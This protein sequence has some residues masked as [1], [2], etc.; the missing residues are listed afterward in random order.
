MAHHVLQEAGAMDAKLPAT[1]GVGGEEGV[2]QEVLGI[3]LSEIALKDFAHS[4]VGDAADGP[5][6][7]KIAGTPKHRHTSLHV[8]NVQFAWDIGDEALIMALAGEEIAVL[9]GALI[10]GRNKVCRAGG[11][12]KAADVRGQD[13]V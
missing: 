4:G 9:F 3:D 1:G 10:N 12:F 8:I 6:V 2:P 11:D 5:E 13:R 7:F